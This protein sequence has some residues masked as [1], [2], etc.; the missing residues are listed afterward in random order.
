MTAKPQHRRLVRPIDLEQ[1]PED[2]RDDA[3]A[4]EGGASMGAAGKVEPRLTVKDGVAE[5][6]PRLRRPDERSGGQ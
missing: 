5:R 3:G 4:V 1:A 6:K 2:E